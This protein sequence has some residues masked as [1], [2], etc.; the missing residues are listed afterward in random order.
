VIDSGSPTVTSTPA[1]SASD[2]DDG[3]V[4]VLLI[5]LGVA[6]VAALAYAVVR[7]LRQSGRLGGGREVSAPQ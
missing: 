5:I 4:P 3:G 6:L 2:S 1:S 7:W